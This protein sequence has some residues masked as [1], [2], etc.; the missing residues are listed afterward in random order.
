MR[1]TLAITVLVS[2]RATPEM[3]VAVVTAAWQETRLARPALETL[4]SP[5]GN[6]AT[7]GNGGNGGLP[8]SGFVAGA[9][10][11][12]EV[13]VTSATQVVA[14]TQAQTATGL[15]QCWGWCGSE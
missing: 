4:G 10:G 9:P 1:A 2:L 14:A 7:Y 5:N 15:G 6:S 8:A 3:A 12:V 13:V 11:G